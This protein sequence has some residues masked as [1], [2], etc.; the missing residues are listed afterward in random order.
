M[1]KPPGKKTRK[2][3]DAP[4]APA[5]LPMVAEEA[6][7]RGADVL[8]LDAGEGLPAGT[9]PP[10]SKRS[11]LPAIAARRPRINLV[12]I[13][14]SAGGLEALRLLLRDLP[15]HDNVSYIIAQHL[16]PTHRS[17]LVE[18]LARETNLTVIEARDGTR[19]RPATIHVVPRGCNARVED[20]RIRLVKSDVRNHPKPSVDMLFASLADDVGDH[21]TAIVLSGTGTDGARGVRAVRAAGGLTIAQDPA[22]AKYDGMP[23]AAIDT[24][25]VDYVLAPDAIAS[26]LDV[27]TRL[28]ADDARGPWEDAPVGTALEKISAEVRARTGLDLSLYKE[29]TMQRR[30]RRRMV[31]TDAQSLEAYAKL[32]GEHPE[33]AQRLAREM[34]ISVTNFFRDAAAFEALQAALADYL[35]ARPNQA[36]FRVWVPG[37]AT[38]EEAYSIAILLQEVLEKQLRACALR[39]FATDID[40]QALAKARRGLYTAA[41]VA[42]VPA[43]LLAKYFTSTGNSHHVVK[44]VRDT[45]IYSTQN[46]TRDPAFLHLDLVSCR[47]VLIYLRPKVQ[48]TMFANFSFA[49]NPGGLLF[50]GKSESVQPFQRFFP[51]VNERARIFWHSASER[52]AGTNLSAEAP[53]MRPASSVRPARHEK[54]SLHERLISAL[55]H[56]LLP[57]SAV[58]DDS[59]ELK[60]VLGDI[61]AF[62]QIS[63]GDVS[64]DLYRLAIRPL[65]V[66]MRSL[67]LKVQRETALSASHVVSHR[68][69]PF[70]IRL[71]ATRLPGSGQ[72][73][74]LTLVSFERYRDV[75]V[76][77]D[78]GDPPS[79]DNDREVAA[80]EQQLVETR[81]HLQTVIEELETSNEELQSLNEEMQSA[82]EELMSANEELETTNEEL[83]S[84]NEE[85]TTLND[86]LESKTYE[87][88]ALNNNLQNVKNSLVYPLVVVDEHR[89][90]VLFNPG[91][92]ELFGLLDNAVGHSLFSLP[93]Y[94]DMGDLPDVMGSVIENGIPVERQ[95][96]GRRSYLMRAEPYV[97]HLGDRRGVVLSFVENTAIRQAEADLRDYAAKLSRSEHFLQSTLDAL[98][99]HICVID[100]RGTILSVNRRWREF[101]L[102]EGGAES[103]CGPG[104]NYIETCRAAAAN[105][106][107]LSAAVLSGL[108]D[109]LERRL[110]RVEIEYPCHSPTTRRWF[111]MTVTPLE[112]EGP[113]CFVVAHEDVSERHRQ[114]AWQRLQARALDDS[115]TAIAIA[116]ARDPKLP[117]TYVNHAFELMTGYT[118]DEAVGMN[119]R[120]LQ[121]T[122]REQP[123][124]ARL[125]S[126]LI[127]GQ[128]ARA[129]LRNYRKNGTQFWNELSIY[130]LE[131]AADELTYFVGVARDVSSLIASED[132]L[133]KTM[134]R[135]KLALSFARVGTFEW[136]I[137]TGR[138]L[139][140]E[141][142]LK[143][144]GI[145]ASKELAFADYQALIHADDRPVFEDAVRLCVAGHDELDLE[146]RVVWPDGT[147]HWLHSKGNVLNDASGVPSRL[148]CLSQE[149]TERK[150]A[151]EQ[152]RFIAHHDAL[153]GLPNRTL[154]RDRLQQALGVAKRN[155]LRVALLFIDLDHFKDVND[156][157]GHQVGDELLQSV[158]SRLRNCV[159]ETDT[160]CRQSGDEFVVI[161]PNIRDSNEAAH[162]ASKIRDALLMPHH[163]GGHDIYTP[164]SIG[165]ALYPDDG[166]ALDLLLRSADTAMYL[167][168]GNGGGRFEFA[169]HEINAQLLE[170]VNLG[171]ELRHGIERGE[172]RLHYQPEID[173]ATGELL[174]ME[175]L[176]RW[177]HPKRGL[178]SPDIFI[179]IAEDSDL[180]HTL[181]DWVLQEA[182]RQNQAWHAAGLG[183]I[184][185]AVNLSPMQ[186]RNAS[187]VEKVTKALHTSGLDP[188][189]LVLEL[190]ERAILRD[191]GQAQMLLKNFE[192]MGIRLAIDDFGTGYGSLSYLHLFSFAKLK[193][194]RSFVAF[195]PGDTG[196]SA[197]VRALISLSH[198]LGIDV[199]AEGVEELEHLEFL[200]QERCTS[201]QGF[202]ASAALEADDATNF[203]LTS[204]A[205]GAALA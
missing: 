50:L 189:Y 78:A 24:G 111:R 45:I 104:V 105:G 116:D 74:P 53:P 17:M 51:P 4:L 58:I 82:N 158:A 87:L 153:T 122:D 183:P 34:L 92:Q 64:F 60:H 204:R 131:D 164:P 192:L 68:G 113:D 11:R 110:P 28:N 107:T 47:N 61:S 201:F 79:P 200:R 10:G 56:S 3:P 114:N 139:N 165:V 91:A 99:Q 160:V 42:D 106:D 170:R 22:S 46:L 176:V 193:I 179:P 102:N 5:P 126:A 18:L 26:R 32:V 12:G 146:Y 196:A 57:P 129:L 55:Q 151:D 199:V 81:E 147:L 76:Q 190:T 177:A 86:E 145:D 134:E 83:Q 143:L 101:M 119:C 20:G 2:G 30:L 39:I 77:T 123:G 117:L 93:C 13:G 109:V 70:P 159:R 23:R 36:E 19:P 31:A 202:F 150:Q 96:N 89:R 121:G 40:N 149:V 180:I 52:I 194:D 7:A 187:I 128:P 166:V 173:V 108:L 16:S 140:S 130:P 182:C 14:A 85:L 49:L 62:V 144:L 80:L 115:M 33:E 41:E 135:E 44:R 25:C 43:G 178:V 29:N 127:E 141:M 21:A 67:V 54:S 124:L 175:A 156:S 161:L 167:A 185:V 75:A 48:E 181:G 169:A 184:T 148:L 69:L 65:R 73:A 37:C 132:A 95:I 168:K 197:I 66:E 98:A 71:T 155:R 203:I 35:A 157:L 90:V 198:S 72:E 118:A 137:R 188:R 138:M 15:G 84:S 97:D 191:V 171:N 103:S 120:F 8:A 142:H 154:M 125:R 152:V 162:V 100:G 63:P 172:L 94:F 1:D 133:R 195:L 205:R 88:L 27:L 186:L 174:G 38:G 59:F 163:L 136:E 9:V 6:T 112:G